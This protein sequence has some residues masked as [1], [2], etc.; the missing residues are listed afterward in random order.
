MIRLNNVKKRFGDKEA[1]KG[2]SLTINKGE[3]IAIIGGSGSG[4]S[5]L[6]RLMIGLDRP[7]SG[8]IYIGG[9]NITAMNENALDRV[10]LR[11]GM[12][13]QYSALFDS[14]SVGENVAFGLREHTDKSNNEIARIVAEKLELVGLP[15]AASL[16]PQELSGGMKKRVGLARAIAT[17]PEIIFYD[18]PSSGLDPIMTAKIDELIIDMQRKLDVTSVVVTHDMASASRISDRIAMI[19]DGE[20]IAVDTAERFQDIKDERVQAFFRTLHHRRE[21][22]A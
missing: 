6:L 9:D 7:T 18:E 16:M 11:M 1:L 10:R 2:I 13:F 20:L 12:V 19:Y 21:A 4:K 14:M 3:T 5:T 22:G 15:D 17:D 8:E